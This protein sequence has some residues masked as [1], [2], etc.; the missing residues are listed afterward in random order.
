MIP[1]NYYIISDHSV[2][3]RV[4]NYPSKNVLL[5]EMYDGQSR[6][7]FTSTFDRNCSRLQWN[8]CLIFTSFQ[9]E[10]QGVSVS[11]VWQYLPSIWDN[12]GFVISSIHR[13]SFF[14]CSHPSSTDSEICT[15]KKAASVSFPGFWI[16]FVTCF[17]QHDVI[18]HKVWKADQKIKRCLQV[19]FVTLYLNYGHGSGTLL[20]SYYA[21]LFS[22]GF[23]KKSCIYYYAA[24]LPISL[25]SILTSF[26][27][28]QS[29][30]L[31]CQI[32]SLAPCSLSF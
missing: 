27:S 17:D 18:R 25:I 7:I 20:D 23:T 13:V 6:F 10:L 15:I 22:N 29:S 11:L 16:V 28:P 8:S 1:L 5:S 24:A 14:V 31:L 3:E 4:Q 19:E 26:L 2:N 12:V 32:L 9:Y 30:L 21:F